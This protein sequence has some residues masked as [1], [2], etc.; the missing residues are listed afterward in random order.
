MYGTH[1]LVN[2]TGKTL[3]AL[4]SANINLDKYIDKK[5]TVNG[6]LIAGY[7]VEGGPDYLNVQAIALIPRAAKVGSPGKSDELGAGLEEKGSR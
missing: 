2:D 7:P 4:K 1:I 6:D 3:Y 5:V